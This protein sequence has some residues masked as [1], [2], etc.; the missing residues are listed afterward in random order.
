MLT[1]TFVGDVN[2]AVDD[3]SAM[4]LELGSL[5]VPMTS[6]RR[7]GEQTSRD[8]PANLVRDLNGVVQNCEAV[9]VKIED[10][11]RRT[12]KSRF[13]CT[14]WILSGWKD[15]QKERSR[16]LA[17]SRALGLTMQLFSL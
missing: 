15:V 3:M 8:L 1:S 12:S 2:D 14:A 9:V 16:L 13:P 11:L 17:H 4:S 7:D 6:L 5:S 10:L